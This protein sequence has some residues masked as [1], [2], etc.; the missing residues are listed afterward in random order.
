MS[1]GVY[2]LFLGKPVDEPSDVDYVPTRFS[3]KDDKRKDAMAVKARK[4]RAEQRRNVI[5]AEESEKERHASAVEGLLL[6]QDSQFAI[7]A[8]TQMESVSKRGVGIQTAVETI[9]TCSQTQEND[10]SSLDAAPMSP[11]AIPS[12]PVFGYEQLS[13]DDSAVRVTRLCYV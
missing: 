1:E 8:G 2:F 10:D 4:A 13:N 9:S 12:S 11:I 5:E 6:I 3:F 7:D